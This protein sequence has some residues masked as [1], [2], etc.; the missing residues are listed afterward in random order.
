MKKL[1]FIFIAIIAT[2][3]VAMLTSPAT[4]KVGLIEVERP[5]DATIRYGDYRINNVMEDS[6]SKYTYEDE[7]MKISWF[8]GS[9][10]FSF[11][12]E[13]KSNQTL[14]INWDEA[15]YIT[16]T[17]STERIMHSGVKYTEKN[18]SQPA[19]IVV[20]NGHITD[21]IMPTSNVYYVSGQYGGWRETPLFLIV[22]SDIEKNAALETY[23][24]KKVKV[25][26]PIEVE[27]VVNE[28]IFS[29]EVEDIILSST[30]Y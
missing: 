25:L 1:S 15:A 10:Q 12:L 23:K 16:H 3:C 6:K 30:A 4:Y 13:N 19:S 7:L 14:K 29:F 18:N 2:S 24:D 11:V 26:L 20:K 22:K 8:V 9:T 27:G 17:G 21:L 5:E 28:Y